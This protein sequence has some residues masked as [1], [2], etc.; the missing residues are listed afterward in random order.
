MD[1]LHV[2]RQKA[3]GWMSGYVLIS[4]IDYE[5]RLEQEIVVRDEEIFV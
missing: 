2:T 3:D 4:C 1:A 5:T